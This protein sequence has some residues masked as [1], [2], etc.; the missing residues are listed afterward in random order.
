MAGR[1]AVRAPFST[2]PPA[3]RIRQS[4]PAAL[5]VLLSTGILIWG[6]AR[7]AEKAPSPSTEG[8]VLDTAASVP[9]HG[10]REVSLG[11]DSKAELVV[12][13]TGMILVRLYD[14][15]W[16]LVD[17]AG[18]QVVVTIITPDGA[19]RD[20]GLEAMG[21]G[22]AAHFMNPMEEAVVAHVRE[23]GS[24]TV[25]IRAVWGGR[26]LVGETRVVGLGTGGKGM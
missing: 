21:S 13:D 7:P 19:S 20:I 18:K 15:G 25:R 26:S 8:A 22:S 6:C 17:P 3:A 11:P 2:R 4:L 14:A 5:V 1:W 10:G 23:Q 9:P 16:H 24:Y 12:D